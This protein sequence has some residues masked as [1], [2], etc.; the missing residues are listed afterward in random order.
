MSINSTKISTHKLIVNSKNVLPKGINR[1]SKSNY[2]LIGKIV[3]KGSICV[4][5]DIFFNCVALQIVVEHCCPGKVTTNFY[6]HC[7][8]K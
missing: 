5:N 8:T 6:N 7:K 2:V 1:R 3:Y 4:M